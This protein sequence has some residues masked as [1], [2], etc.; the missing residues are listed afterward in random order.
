[1]EQLDLINVLP[2]ERKEVDSVYEK[3]FNFYSLKIKTLNCFSK[4]IFGI[5]KTFKTFFML[6]KNLQTLFFNKRIKM[7]NYIEFDRKHI[8]KG[9][10]PDDELISD[11]IKEKESSKDKLKKCFKNNEIINQSYVKIKEYVSELN[12]FMIVK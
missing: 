10:N 3:K 6:F 11:I 5:L 1:L 12:D 2:E 4:T 8:N 9:Q 7:L